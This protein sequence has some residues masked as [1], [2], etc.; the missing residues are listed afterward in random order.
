MQKYIP[1]NSLRN[2]Y[3][4]MGLFSLPTN[5]VVFDCETTGNNPYTSRII[6]IGAIKYHNLEPIDTF[7]ILIN[8]DEA[9]PFYITK[10]T[11]ISNRDLINQPTINFVLPLFCS[12]IQDLPLV[13]HNA[14]FDV[15]MIAAE[16]Y[17]C[18]MP[19][20]K[21]KIIDTLPMA[22][23][24]IPKPLIENHKLVTIKEFLGLVNNSHRALDDC[25]TCNSIYQ[26]YYHNFQSK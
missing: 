8:P 3:N 15:Q 6:E 5:Y 17:R 18:N 20:L 11:G 14:P 26:L 22:R 25:E 13:A 24:T 10:L 9:L 19:F 2:C 7:N 23:V 16:A 4:E 12:F 1:K 21:N